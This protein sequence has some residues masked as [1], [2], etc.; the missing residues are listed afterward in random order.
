MGAYV[1]GLTRLVVRSRLPRGCGAIPS[2]GFDLHL[3]GMQ[4]VRNGLFP[5]RNVFVADGFFGCIVFA[6]VVVTCGFSD[7]PADQQ[8]FFFELLRSIVHAFFRTGDI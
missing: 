1:T 4:Q 7:S 3:I 2:P 8:G 6:V 5:G